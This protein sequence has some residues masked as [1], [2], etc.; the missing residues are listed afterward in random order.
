MA[1]GTVFKLKLP[2]PDYA[3]TSVMRRTFSVTVVSHDG[4]NVVLS[5]SGQLMK[6]GTRYAMVYVGAEMKDPQ[7][8]QRL[9]RVESPCCDLMTDRVTPNFSYGRLENVRGQLDQLPA[10]ALQVR[11]QLKEVAVAKGA[12]GDAQAVTVAP[13][14]PPRQA[15]V[16][17]QEG[18][19]APA[20][21]K[22]SDD[23]W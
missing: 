19:A 10:G 1:D 11:E 23:K 3:I 7:T 22:S 17:Q 4:V 15:R 21:V 13:A 9:G 8:G 18:S 16:T 20:S 2:E 6:E 5:Q 12:M 14:P